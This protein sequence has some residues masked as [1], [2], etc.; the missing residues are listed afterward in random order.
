MTITYEVGVQ[1]LALAMLITLTLLQRPDL[2]VAALLY[3]VVMPAT[4]LLWLPYA[5]RIIERE[6]GSAEAVPVAAEMHRH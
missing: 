4:A 2:A 5:K 1:N 3:A 6:Y